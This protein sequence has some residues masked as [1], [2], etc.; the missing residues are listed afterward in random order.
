MTEKMYDNFQEKYKN[1]AFQVLKI[2][3]IKTFERLATLILIRQ[4]G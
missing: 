3:K 2:C 4:L 1:I